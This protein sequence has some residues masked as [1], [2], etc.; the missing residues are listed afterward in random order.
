MTQDV[1][2]TVRPCSAHCSEPS[3]PLTTLAIHIF[4]SSKNM[5]MSKY[6]YMASKSEKTVQP[7]ADCLHSLQ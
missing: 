2:V 6:G 7:L 4:D 5:D 3:V 1:T